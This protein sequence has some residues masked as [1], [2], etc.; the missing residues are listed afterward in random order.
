MKDIHVRAIGEALNN[1][2]GREG[3]PTGKQSVTY[4]L[5]GD[6]LILKFVTVVHFAEERSLQLQ[7]AR[8]TDEA[9]Q[10]LGGTLSNL[11]SHFKERAGETLKIKEIDNR[12]DIE[13]ISA[14]AHSPRKIAYYR[15]NH[16]FQIE[17]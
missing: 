4:S 3:S 9:V 13:L 16:T 12:D 11:K 17:N 5:H 2:F 15:R 7:V 8:I 1:T 14:S 6:Q 10:I